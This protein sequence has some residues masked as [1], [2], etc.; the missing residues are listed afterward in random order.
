[1]LK[2]LILKR[3]QKINLYPKERLCSQKMTRAYLSGGLPSLCDCSYTIIDK[4][5]IDLSTLALKE[6]PL[7]FGNL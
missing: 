3:S 6:I 5:K 2:L 1:M 4:H 7:E